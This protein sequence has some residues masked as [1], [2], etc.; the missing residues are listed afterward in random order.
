[1]DNRQA[2]DIVIAEVKGECQMH[3]NCSE[4]PLKWVCDDETPYYLLK[5]M[6]EVFYGA[7]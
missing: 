5:Q 2:W 3:A 1:M 6:K 7:D 4:C